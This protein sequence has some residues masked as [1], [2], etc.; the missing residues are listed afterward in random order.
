VAAECNERRRV[1]DDLQPPRVIW[2]ANG[3]K[4]HAEFACR[5]DLAFGLVSR[6]DHR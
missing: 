6:A 5:L 1:I 3:N 4:F 2:F